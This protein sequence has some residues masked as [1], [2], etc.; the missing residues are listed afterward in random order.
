MERTRKC[1]GRINGWIDR[2]KD[3]QTKAISIIPNPLCSGGLKS[4]FFKVECCRGNQKIWLPIIK[5]I[6]WVD[7]HQIIITAKYESHHFTGYGESVI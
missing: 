1:Y 6:N 2:W 5:H 4:P 7:D 3:G